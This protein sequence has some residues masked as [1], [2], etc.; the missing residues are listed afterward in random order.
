MCREGFP[1]QLTPDLKT[2]YLLKGCRTQGI[3]AGGQ[4]APN[5]QRCHETWGDPGM[6]GSSVVWGPGGLKDV[7]ERWN[8]KCTIKDVRLGMQLRL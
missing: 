3:S 5:A 7:G 1:E 2:S 8:R 6:E 4:R